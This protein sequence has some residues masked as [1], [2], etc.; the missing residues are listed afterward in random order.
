MALAKRPLGEL[1]LQAG[2]VGPDDLARA[3]AAQKSSGR[4]LG[5]LL[6]ALGL[7]TEADVARGLASQ[8]GIPFVPDHE[9]Q[10]DLRVA[11]LL[12]PTLSRK[13]QALPLR[14][15]PDHLVVAMSDPLDVFSLDEI[16]HRTRTRVEAVACTRQGLMKA[17]AQYERL[18]ALKQ[19]EGSEGAMASVT[20][21]GPEPD[22][23]PISKLVNQMVDQAIADQASDI[24]I[25]PGEQQF[26][27]RLRVDGFLREFLTSAMQFHPA[28]TARIKVLAS[29]D[30]SERRSPQDGRIQLRDRGRKIDIRVS[31]L[32]TVYG[33][34]TVLRLFDKSRT[35][36][37][38]EELGFAPEVFDWYTA[39]ANRPNGMLLVTGPTGSGKTSTLISTLA[40]LNEAEK[41]I[42]TIEDPVEYQLPGV[43]HVQVNQRT[44]LSFADGLRA[45]LRQ[46]P[47]IIMVGEVRDGE[48]A[49]VAVR[50]ALTGHLVLSTL[51]TN[52][53]AGAL[54]RLM[55]MG[56]EPYLI[57]SS[58]LG[59]L[60]QRLLRRL[61]PH[62]R[63]PYEAEPDIFA[64]Y[65]CAPAT[66]GPLTLYRAV[67]CSHCTGTGYAG[68]FPIFEFL[69]V[70]P[71]IQALVTRRAALGEVRQQAVAE[72]MRLLVAAGL[73]RA[74]EGWTTP[75]EVFRVA[76][77]TGDE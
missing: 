15:E 5:E 51:H 20:P 41:N 11:K 43:N 66:P 57:A 67:G 26:R 6:V 72:G 46:D 34:K 12:P 52:D 28:I 39:C 63:Q 53:A 9:I 48:T 4:R 65:G 7:V 64:A 1:L 70:T 17:I 68:R 76:T 25:E 56:V 69:R 30:I 35:L 73:Q 13:T 45:I 27:V 50:S 42:V 47:N 71:S 38:L 3:L 10:V 18:A 37:R 21:L 33:E 32:P 49:D 44:G 60:A 61:C 29:L 77:T 8:L 19:R 59:V 24:H 40:Y 16:R 74:M 58:V 36:P 2:L 55:D 62:C 22:D 31:T 14:Q 23:A 75:E 54:T